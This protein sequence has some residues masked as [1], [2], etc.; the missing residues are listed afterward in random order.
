MAIYAIT[1]KPRSGKT[2]YLAYL[3]T[4]WIKAGE[5]IYSN[6]YVDLNAPVFKK[7]LKKNDLVANYQIKEKRDKDKFIIHEQHIGREENNIIGDL[8]CPEDLANEK[9]QVFFWRN[10]RDWNKMKSG[11]II[12]DEGTRYFN[13]RKWSMLSEETEIKLQQH[14]KEDL[15]IYLTTQHYSR[16]DITLRVLIETFIHAEKIIGAPGS[17]PRTPF[18]LIKLTEHYLEDMDRMERASKEDV[19]AMTISTEYLF[20]RKKYAATYDTR[21]MVGKSDTMELWHEERSCAKCGKIAISH[22]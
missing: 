6:V 9:K 3:I 5:R 20:I 19:E 10:M 1:G 16:L 2:Y 8:D 21:Q 18:G 17:N 13:P 11:I 4:K 12:A 22:S 7:Y 14:G 15:D